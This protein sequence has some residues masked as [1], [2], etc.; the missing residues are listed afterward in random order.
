[1]ESLLVLAVPTVLA[2]LV[3]RAIH[4]R[5]GFVTEVES[6]S[7]APTLA[8]GQRLLARRQ[9][10]ARPLSRGDI[11]VVDSAELD[12]PIIKRVVGL[13]GEHIDV[14]ADGLVQVAGHGLAEPYVVHGGGRPGAFDVP[15]GHLLLLGDNRARSSDARGWRMPYVPVS[16][17]LGRVVPHAPSAPSTPR[18][19][20][21]VPS[22]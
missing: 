4:R 19:R 21:R 14:G 16:A 15:S 20:S 3:G 18:V 7:M 22:G 9:R 17:V 6:V 2:L 10:A 1:M 11:V 5:L 12:R 8:S 13:P